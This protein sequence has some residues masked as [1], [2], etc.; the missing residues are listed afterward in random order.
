M[1]GDGS[2]GSSMA[3]ESIVAMLGGFVPVVL[4]IVLAIADVRGGALLDGMR[5]R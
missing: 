2:E 4:L 3:I 5:E 1:Q